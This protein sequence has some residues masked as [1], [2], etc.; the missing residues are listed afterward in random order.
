MPAFAYTALDAAGKQVTGSLS[1]STRAEAYRKLEAQ[2]L[3][4]IKVSEDEVAAKAAA[5]VKAEGEGP[6][7]KLSRAQLI[8]FT[9]ELADLMDG[10]LQLEQALRVMHERQESPILRKVSGRIREQ[11]REGAMFSKAL[12]HASPSF[13]EMYCNLSAA[14]EVSGSLPQ[15]LRRLSAG[16]SQMHE[17]QSRVK[18]ALI[19]PAFLFGAVVMLLMIFSLFLVPK[20]SEMLSKSR[21]AMPFMMGVLVQFNAFV[22]KWWWLGLALITTGV[23]LFRGYISRPQGRMWWDRA[24][25]KIPVFGSILTARFYAQFASSLGNLINN[26]IPL[27]NALRLTA[28]TTAN[29]YLRGLLDQATVY[30]GEG[31]SL[32]GALR[33]VGHLP[34]MLID[35]IAMGEQTG[36][37]GKAMEKIALRFDK[38]LDKTVKNMMA[39]LTPTIL[40]FLFVIVGVV[41][42][43]IVSAIFGAMAGVRSRA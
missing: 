9:E 23:I 35:M 4:P 16:I 38:E 24:R 39:M 18:S 1:V 42:V 22:A 31:A 20:F 11:L 34:V 2:R 28:K 25:L 5:V 8:L 30:L 41:A 15:I 14:G 27:L 26:G 21:T 7:P 6:P 13:D 10:G 43:S 40:I 12:Q 17:L 32:S 33:K 19:Y 29:V 3:V 37:L 36:R